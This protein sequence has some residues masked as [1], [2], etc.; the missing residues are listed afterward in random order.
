M[1]RSI[2]KRRLGP[3]SHRFPHLGTLAVSLIGLLPV[4]NACYAWS[5]DPPQGIPIATGLSTTPTFSITADGV[6]GVFA[7]W[8]RQ[9]TSSGTLFVQHV[10][11]SGTRDPLW[12]VAGRILSIT[13]EHRP[14]VVSDGRGGAIVVA[15]AV[16]A[17]RIHVLAWHVLSSGEIDPN[18]P[19]TGM[20]ICLSLYR[21]WDVFAVTDGAGGVLA[22]WN[23]FRG[24]T[25]NDIYSAHLD[26]SGIVTPGSPYSGF[27]I[28]TAVRHQTLT[29]LVAYQGGAYAAIHDGRSSYFDGDVYVHHI[30][31]DGS[32]DP[33]WP[34]NGL[35][36]ST[37]PGN[38][39]P[40][41]ITAGTNGAFVQW[42][43]DSD[44]Q[45]RVNHTLSSGTLDPMWPI[46]GILVSPSSL[47]QYAC[48]IA[49]DG[50]G[51]VVS[52]LLDGDQVRV[53]RTNSNGL[54][55]AG[56]PAGGVSVGT[57]VQGLGA[58]AG[59]GDSQGGMIV[60]WPCPTPD[61]NV[62]SQHVLDA[63][64]I[65]PTWP[66]GGRMVTLEPGN[67]ANVAATDDSYGGAIVAWTLPNG[68]YAAKVPR[69]G[70]LDV[71]PSTDD[72]ATLAIHPNPAR[73]SITLR[74]FFPTSDIMTISLH[75]TQGRL[76]HL[77]A[78]GPV[79]KGV[80]SFSFDAHTISGG[81][82]LP[83]G[84]YFLRLRTSREEANAKLII[85]D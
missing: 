67:E 70:S 64:Y 25:D 56:W 20:P 65:D 73:Q 3:G 33:S 28:S 12:P 8:R 47:G 10:I 22:G 76:I 41:M 38:I 68:L 4:E 6:G 55:S 21:Q 52:L 42:V 34:T 7:A 84:L 57:L 36:V 5:Y 78:H 9:D 32:A 82:A 1:P 16:Y 30:L 79:L 58:P 14:K 66:N 40:P 60:V 2:Y 44:G 54:P 46:N 17:G 72:I 24:S 80:R 63:G 35:A 31:P 27:P 50:M 83:H 51:G 59:V 48:S 13:C 85:A 77:V 75:D 11:A 43:D 39:S 45:V 74:C 19:S 53:C 81:H 26:S 61:P 49:S 71:P 37:L 23:D 62:C 29:D 69:S 15:T 18:W